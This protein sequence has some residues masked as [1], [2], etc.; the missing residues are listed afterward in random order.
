M[1]A[2]LFLQRNCHFNAI[3]IMALTCVRN[4]HNAMILIIVNKQLILCINYVN[5][6]INS[7]A[8]P[9]PYVHKCFCKDTYFIIHYKLKL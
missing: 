7:T 3:V 2:I 9:S 5:T 6:S 1:I 4:S 8:L